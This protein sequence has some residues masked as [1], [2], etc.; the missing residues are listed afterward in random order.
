MGTSSSKEN[1]SSA[2]NGAFGQPSASASLS[3]VPDWG[4]D[5]LTGNDSDSDVELVDVGPDEGDR[6]GY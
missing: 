1:S 4:N 2:G 3:G 5:H 6:V